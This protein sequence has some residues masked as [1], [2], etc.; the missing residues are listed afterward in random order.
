MAKRNALRDVNPVAITLCKKGANRQRIF[1]RKEAATETLLELP[2]GHMPILKEGD[3][4]T[5]LYCVVAA[6]GAEEDPGL[7]GEEG[8][9]DV[10][11]SADEIRK[12]AHRLLKNGAFVNIA[13]DDPAAPGCAIVESAV[14]LTDFEIGG[15][16]VEIGSWYVGIEPDAPIRKQVE[17]GEIEAISL[18]GTGIRVELEKAD[19]KAQGTKGKDRDSGT[20]KCSGCGSKVKAGITTCPNCKG[21][22]AKSA[23]FAEV[24][25]ERELTDSLWRAWSALEGVIFDAFRDED[26]SDPKGKV[27]QSL[28]EFETYLLGKLDAVPAEDRQALAKD[29]GTLH[30]NADEEEEMGLTDDFNALKKQIEDDKAEREAVKK[31]S[32]AT[33]A[34][35]EGLV[36]LTSKLVERVEALSGAA[37]PAEAGKEGEKGEKGE[38]KKTAT[39]E[40]VADSLGRLADRLDTFDGELTGIAKSVGK[41]AEGDSSQDDDEDPPRRTKVNKADNPLAGLLLGG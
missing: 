23:T 36:G 20:R 24:I 35:V 25:A 41:L 8:S 3:D 19:P 16:L 32:D 37:K 27:R 5:T 4:W 10:W 40:S 14:A 39:I 18:E 34:A 1:L 7:V 21:K 17:D 9:V 33:T 22:I 13:H 6:P 15:E 11:E 29:L 38:V 30:P 2:S 26:E 31:A 12:A 28:S